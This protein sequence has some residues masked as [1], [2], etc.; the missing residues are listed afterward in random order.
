MDLDRVRNSLDGYKQFGIDL[1]IDKIGCF[2]SNNEAVSALLDSFEPEL[3]KIFKRVFFP[4]SINILWQVIQPRIFANDNHADNFR[5]W[6]MFLES[7]SQS[8]FVNSSRDALLEV[9]AL[10]GIN[11][12][13]FMDAFDGLLG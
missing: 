2:D 11:E 9:Y 10:I 8:T 5:I 13:Q 1:V 3:I 12:E 7:D 4:H 6:L